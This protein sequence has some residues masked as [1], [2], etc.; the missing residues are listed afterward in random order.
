MNINLA[1]VADLYR[2]V[3]S[4]VPK[5]EK[6]PFPLS[7]VDLEVRQIFE[8]FFLGGNAFS[9]RS[10]FLDEELAEGVRSLSVSTTYRPALEWVKPYM[11][12]LHLAQYEPFFKEVAE[13]T[14]SGVNSHEWENIH[15]EVEGED[16]RRGLMRTFQGW[17]EVAARSHAFRHKAPVRLWLE[18]YQLDVLSA[19]QSLGFQVTDPERLGRFLRGED[20][21]MALGFYDQ[22]GGR[23]EWCM[24][25]GEELYRVPMHK[26]ISPPDSLNELKILNKT[27]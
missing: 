4:E 13:F 14:Y 1:E 25:L 24:W 17:M 2:Y 7:P 21:E 27:V 23:R 22:G 18:P 3:P 20:D 12:T 8:R 9:K 19:F 26:I 16:R 10:D 5:Q 15:R 6:G 11:L